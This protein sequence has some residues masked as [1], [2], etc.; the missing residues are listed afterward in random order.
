[1]S[2][3]VACRTSLNKESAKKKYSDTASSAHRLR[4]IDSSSSRNLTD[5]TDKGRGGKDSATILA[6]EDVITVPG[7]IHVRHDYLV[8]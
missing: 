4:N 6:E 8:N 1:V 7:V 5:G 3:L 2:C